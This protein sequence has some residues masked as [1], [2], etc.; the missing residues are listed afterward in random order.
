MGSFPSRK[1]IQNKRIVCP[2]NLNHEAMLVYETEKY[3]FI[4]CP[5]VHY[6]LTANTPYSKPPRKKPKRNIVFMVQKNA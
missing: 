4:R 6:H 5:R 1:P 2:I 3:R